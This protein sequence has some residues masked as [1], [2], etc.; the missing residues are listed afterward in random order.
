ML[1]CYRV[2]ETQLVFKQQTKT[3]ACVLDIRGIETEEYRSYILIKRRNDRRQLE[4]LILRETR[5]QACLPSQGT[6]VHLPG[7]SSRFPGYSQSKSG[8]QNRIAN[9]ME[10]E[11]LESPRKDQMYRREEKELVG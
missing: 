4:G 8:K 10:V 7:F 2:H 5:N 3:S 6:L 11:W 9:E 1:D